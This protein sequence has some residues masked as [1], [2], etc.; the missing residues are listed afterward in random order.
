MTELV[1][2]TDIERIVGAVRHQTVHQARAVSKE[3]TVYIL[4]SHKCLE[5]GIDLRECPYSLALDNG[6]DSDDWRGYEDVALPVAI[7]G[8]RLFPVPKAL[9]GSDQ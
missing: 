3:Q 1:P 5:S 9:E 7:I 4:H 2:A 8:R 6:I